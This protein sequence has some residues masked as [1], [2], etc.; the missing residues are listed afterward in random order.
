MKFVKK[1]KEK[2]TFGEVAGKSLDV[3]ELARQMGLGT[4]A[5]LARK[6]GELAAAN[7]NGHAQR[8]AA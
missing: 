7:D 8:N 6:C 4:L 1:A 5:A 2:A 3:A